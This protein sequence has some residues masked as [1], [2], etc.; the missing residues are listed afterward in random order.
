MAHPVPA[1]STTA[2][3]AWLPEVYGANPDEN[4]S[5]LTRFQNALA[6]FAALAG[7]GPVVLFRAPG[8]VN[9]I[10]EHTDYSQGYVM[11]V[12]LDKDIV[13]LAR[14]RG[15]GIVNLWSMEPE[16][17]PARSFTTGSEI[18]RAPLGDWSNYTRGAAQ[19]LSVLAQ[20]R[21]A[22]MDALVDGRAPWGVPVAAGLSSS[23]ALL[24]VSA[25]ALAAINGLHLAGERLAHLCSEAEWYVGTRGGIMD[26]FISI[27]AQRDRALLLDCRPV[28]QAGQDAAR[29]PEYRMAHV[30]LPAGYRI[31]ICN[32]GVPREKTRS[33]Y[34]MRAA[35]CR[36]AV[37]ILHR[38]YPNITHLRDV[39][40]EAFELPMPQ[41]LELLARL[42][43]DETTAAELRA[44]GVLDATL[45]QML[46]DYGLD[47]GQPF[48]ILPRCRHVVTENA[49]VLASRDAMLAGDAE[50]LGRLI[51]QA[52]ESMSGDYD[53]SCPE[54]DLLAQLCRTAPGVAGARVTGAGWGGCVVVLVKEGCED[55]V[56]Q[57]VAGRYQQATGLAAET[58]VCRPAPGAGQAPVPL[59]VERA[60]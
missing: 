57:A 12:A 37:A 5:Q 20:G 36:L 18:P 30:P 7:P 11:P 6:R 50:M 51:N 53:A 29:G 54:V 22:G 21:I 24:V 47:A 48:R 4:L 42:L 2:L 43:P 10:G 15:D 31:L 41:L 25:V 52:H 28:S 8:R 45:E 32:S 23:S 19:A 59:A 33:Q 3:R 40:P 55:A 56:V 9:L 35:E 38:H 60:Q 27:L 58:F 46:L 16:R 1:G 34:N 26:Q 44:A 17:F 13:L 39:S 49:R 14:P